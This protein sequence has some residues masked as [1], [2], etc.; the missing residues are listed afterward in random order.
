VPYRVDLRTIGAD[1]L[2]RLIDLGALDVEPLTGSGVAAL[3][4]DRVPPAQLARELG[5]EEVRVSPAVGRDADS[6]WILHPR[7]IQ[8]GAATLRMLD[9]EAFGTGLH[10][11]TTLC[12]DALRDAVDGTVPDRVLDVGV[13][14]GVLAL[15]ALLLGVPRATGIDTDGEA[16]LVAAGNARLNALDGRLELIRGGPERVAGTWPLVLANVLAA[17]LIEMAPSLVRRV[18]HRG[19][20][21]LSGIPASVADDVDRAYRRLGMHHVRSTTREGWTALVMHASW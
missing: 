6:V 21:V 19:Q 14:S 5:V 18:G 20:L 13:G 9:S 1:T 11:S 10:P 16:L 7:P 3:M 15:A 12:L 17:P 8:V 4:P 2:D